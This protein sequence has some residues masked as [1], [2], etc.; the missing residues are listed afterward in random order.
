YRR[1]AAGS[2]PGGYIQAPLLLHPLL[3][4]FSN[5][6]PEMSSTLMA[7][8]VRLSGAVAGKSSRLGPA[9]LPRRLRAQDGDRVTHQQATC[10]AAPRTATARLSATGPGQGSRT[11]WQPCERI[12]ASARGRRLPDPRRTDP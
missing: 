8:V 2:T 3:R 1:N 6:A 5:S 7:S 10:S 9:L 4:R 11:R 12:S